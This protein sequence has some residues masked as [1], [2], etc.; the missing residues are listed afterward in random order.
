MNTPPFFALQKQTLNGETTLVAVDYTLDADDL[1]P[2]TNLTLYVDTLTIPAKTFS[3]PGKNITIV[4]RQILAESGATLDTSGPGPSSP[5]V[6]INPPKAAGGSGAGKPG[7]PGLDGGS[8]PETMGKQGQN[9]GNISINASSIAGELTVKAVGG[10]GQIGQDGQEGGDGI[11]G[12]AGNDAIINQ[13]QHDWHHPDGWAITPATPGGNGGDGGKGGN[14]GKSGDGGDGGHI[15]IH[16]RSPLQT[17]QV[18]IVCQG[19]QPGKPALPGKGGQLGPAGPGGRIAVQHETGGHF[20]H[21][22]WELSNER[23][24]GAIDGTKG[25]DGDPCATPAAQ[26]KETAPDIKTIADDAVFIAPDNFVLSLAQLTLQY[27]EIKYFENDLAT[28]LAYYRWLVFLSA[29]PTQDQG[30]STELGGIHKQCAILQNQIGQGLDYFGNPVDYVPIVTLNYYQ[31]VLDSMLAS[32]GQIELVYNQYCAYLA[33]QTHEFTGMRDAIAQANDAI[34]DYKKAQSDF[35]EKINATGA[36]IDQLGSALVAQYDVLMASDKAFQEA[37]VKQG[38]GC[39]FA[40]FLSILK[41][42]LTVGVDAYSMFT[43]PNVKTITATIK[44]FADIGINISTG[45]LLVNP[46]AVAGDPNS[47]SQG[48]QQINP[49]G[50]DVDDSAK[51]IAEGNNFDAAIK[52]YLDLPEA[53]IYQQAV[54]DYIG[55]AQS[56]NAKLLE[57]TNNCIQYMALDGKIS[58]KQQEVNRISSQI[59]QEN[60]PGLISYRNFLFSLYQDYKALCLKYLYQE[61]RAFEYWS[62]TSNPFHVS[63]NSFVGL[64]EMH[65]RLKAKIID[66]INNYSQPNQPLNDIRILLTPKFRELQFRAMQQTGTITFQITPDDNAFLGWANVLLTNFKVILHGVSPSENKNIYVQ[67]THNGRVCTMDPLGVRTDYT[68]RRV[69]SIYEYT[70]TNGNLVTVAGGSLGGDGTGGNPNRIALSPFASFTINIP[71]KYN[72]G[73]DISDLG[74]IE[75]SFSGYASPM[76]KVAR[77]A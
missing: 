24:G 10:D 48:W 33:E 21:T 17:N 46:V 68:H 58:Q 15:T 39:S 75:I 35:Y 63:D 71:P 38:M 6:P 16:T 67:L 22:V 62:Q 4:A 60:V 19:G 44:D 57:Y 51:L 20:N 61:N 31:Q 53:K 74:G 73:I 11:V 32:G 56:R 23:Q 34:A 65:N 36:S 47:I 12:Y 66:W 27:A 69:L 40:N 29:Q 41:T 13:V 55:I 9:A 54:H 7:Q 25:K 5:V 64:S 37:V 59:A 45:K 43:D 8:A 70:I 18:K 52:P 14:A 76:E 50:G 1:D 30:L 28:A 77:P 26:G 3:L 42:I 49:G 2:T 72:P